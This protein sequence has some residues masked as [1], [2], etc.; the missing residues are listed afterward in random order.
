[1]ARPHYPDRTLN[2]QNL[3]IG[4]NVK[5]NVRK[6]RIQMQKNNGKKMILKNVNLQSKKIEGLFGSNANLHFVHTFLLSKIYRLKK[7]NFV[8]LFAFCFLTT[9]KESGL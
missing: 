4:K 5:K 8:L 6:K 3:E 1:M 9:D 2:K 7:Y